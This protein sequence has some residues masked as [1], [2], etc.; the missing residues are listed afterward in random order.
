M[1]LSAEDRFVLE[2]ADVGIQRAGKPHLRHGRVGRRV[3]GRIAPVEGLG[4]RRPAQARE[5]RAVKLGPVELGVGG[6]AA[7]AQVDPLIEQALV[8]GQLVQAEGDAVA[9]VDPVV[10]EIGAARIAGKGPALYVGHEEMDGAA[11]DAQDARC[12]EVEAEVDQ[13]LERPAALDAAAHVAK[14]LRQVLGDDVHA[15][16]LVHFDNLEVW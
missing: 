8:V 10:V 7:N 2:H 16:A 5:E 6:E 3:V 14:R 9:G 13:A 4:G 1:A 12:V 11:W 15:M